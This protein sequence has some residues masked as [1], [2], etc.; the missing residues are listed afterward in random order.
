MR[1]STFEHLQKVGY[2]VHRCALGSDGNCYYLVSQRVDRNYGDKDGRLFKAYRE[3]GEGQFEIGASLAFFVS[4]SA[5]GTQRFKDLMGDFDTFLKTVGSTHLLILLQRDLSTVPNEEIVLTT[6]SPDDAFTVPAQSD[7]LSEM[8]DVRFQI[9]RILAEKHG[10]GIKRV[11]KEA[12]LEKLC[13]NI[14][15]VDKALVILEEEKFLDGAFR[16]EMK[17]LTAGYLEAEKT[18]PQPAPKIGRIFDVAPNTNEIRNEISTENQGVSMAR[19]VEQTGSKES[20]W[21]VFISHASEDKDSFVRPLAS[22]LSEHGV[23]VWFDEFSL[24]IGDSLRRSIERG[25]SKSRYGIVVISPDFLRKEWPQRELDGLVAR[26]ID[27]DKVILPIWYEISEIDIRSVSPMLADRVAARA[28]TGMDQVVSDLMRV[29]GDR[30][31]TPASA[32]ETASEE[33]SQEAAGCAPQRAFLSSTKF[34]ADRFAQAFPG[35]REVRW[36]EDQNDIA[37]H[38]EKLLEPPLTVSDTRPIW[39]WGRGNMPIEEFQRLNA[40]TFLMDIQ[41]LKIDKIAAIHLGSYF[42]HF[43]YVQVEPMPPTG[44]YANVSESI[45]R[46][47]KEF[48]YCSEEYGLVEGETLVT[49]NELDDGAAKIGGKL[50]DIRGIVELRVRYLTPY[51]FLIAPHMSPIN[52]NEFDPILREMLNEMLAGRKNLDQLIEVVR[53]LPK[54]EPLH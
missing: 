50:I 3:V 8:R 33:K 38:L 45:D 11:T 24:T 40:E 36:F 32:T 53:K 30:A 52:N 5:K 42:R 25:L 9:L 13:T 44:L 39:W 10:A 41:E 29:I 22:R 47:L 12:L 17:L 1:Q 46:C 28:K 14:G 21:D 31:S 26:E 48:G 54:K 43:V 35:D 15:W 6:G 7:P 19:S 18:I 49:R 34:F 51:N 4:R 27:G 23:K 2:D 20:D 16:G 37:L